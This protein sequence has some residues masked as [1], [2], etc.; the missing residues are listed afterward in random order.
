MVLH[1]LLQESFTLLLENVGA[2]TSHNP[3]VLHGLLQDSFT[4][5]FYTGNWN[6]DLWFVVNVH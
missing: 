3:M 2:P 1:G 5:T 6:A 4:F